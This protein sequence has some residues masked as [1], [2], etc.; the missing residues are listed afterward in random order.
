M[1][2]DVPRSKKGSKATV[3][4]VL[5]KAFPHLRTAILHHPD[6]L[7]HKSYK[8]WHQEAPERITSTMDL[9]RHNLSAAQH[10]LRPCAVQVRA[11]TWPPSVL[12]PPSFSPP[13]FS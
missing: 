8:E 13:S 3:R 6:C 5:F 12:L 11:G 10:A 1:A 9:L 2:G 7:R 4:A